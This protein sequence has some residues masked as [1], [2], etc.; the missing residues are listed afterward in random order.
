[1]ARA[2]GTVRL[3]VP[4]AGAYELEWS[5]LHTST[6]AEI[7]IEQD[8]WQTIRIEDGETRAIDVLLT[9]DELERALR[10]ARGE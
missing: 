8:E 4:A 3:R 1:V 10:A 2:D 7:A 6:G 5:V 9:A